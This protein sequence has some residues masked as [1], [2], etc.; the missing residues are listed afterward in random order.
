MGLQKYRADERGEVCGNG[1]RPYYCRWM[2]GPTLALIRDCPTPFGS[3]T[4][5]T[6]GEPDTFFSIP[7][8]TEFRKRRILGFV[9]CTDGNWEFH[10]YRGGSNTVYPCSETEK[11]TS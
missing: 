5:Y 3:R 10:P 2:G 7:A 4:V 9:T 6:Q 1:A 11:E 8:A